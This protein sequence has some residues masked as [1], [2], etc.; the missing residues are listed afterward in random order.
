MIALLLVFL[1]RPASADAPIVHTDMRTLGV[2][3][4]NPVVKL[5]PS[6]TLGWFH[7]WTRAWLPSSW[8][9][10]RAAPRQ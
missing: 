10:S 4:G 3:I 5:E 9:G 6:Y 1:A 7:A 8:L 2:H